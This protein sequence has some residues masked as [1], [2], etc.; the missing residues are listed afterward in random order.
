LSVVL[1][2]QDNIYPV[3]VLL[4]GDPPPTTLKFLGK[5]SFL[6]KLFFDQIVEIRLNPFGLNYNSAGAIF[7]LYMI[8]VKGL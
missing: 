7:L 8:L 4:G 6:V 3:G 2:A 1:S 5:N